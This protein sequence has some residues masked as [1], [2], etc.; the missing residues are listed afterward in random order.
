M[1][2]VVVSLCIVAQ[3]EASSTT[4]YA[5]GN[6]MGWFNF[7]TTFGNVQVSTTNMTGYA[8]SQNFGW[9]NLAPSG[10]GVLN[11]G[12]GNL[13]GYAWS[14]NAGWINFLGVSINSSTGVF[15]GTAS[16]TIA[17]SVN[18]SCTNCSVNTS[19]RAV[20]SSPLSVLNTALNGGSN[21][22][23]VPNA[24]T[25]VSV[26]ATI[27]DTS[28]CSA[29]TG[30]TTTIL[31]YRS[32]VTS[33]SCLTGS[34]NGYSP[35]LNCYIATAFTASSTCSSNAVNATT[36]F[37]VYYFA[38]AT[39]A[40]SS[41]PSQ[42]WMATVNFTDTS[43]VT[44]SQDS[45]GHALLTMTALNV[46]PSAINYG[47]VNPNTDTGLKNQSTTVQNVGNA[48]STF[49]VSG[50]ALA[51]STNTIATSSQHYATGTFTFGGSEQ[52]LNGSPTTISG[53]FLTSPTSTSAVSGPLY[54]GVGIPSGVTSGTYSGTV[55]LTSI[56][57]P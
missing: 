13:S 47:T 7:G 44:A 3:A 12:L 14:Q 2:M 10:S 55:T 24:T 56:F 45:V 17:G 40:S 36:T 23:L 4:G 20:T 8:W 57:N 34:G 43:K 42:N 9:I 37:G 27:N 38:Q 18:F 29:I 6:R 19:W 41:F 30:G 49:Q 35:S 16:G 32:G 33:S 28:G 39:D 54:W 1:V 21:I 48:S 51:S 25:S 22:V 31:L 46:T 53:F 50:T 15:G 26:S 5:W 11:D 52:Q